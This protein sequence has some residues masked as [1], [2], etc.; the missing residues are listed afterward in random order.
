MTDTCKTCRFWNHISEA[1]GWCQRFP[2][3]FKSDLIG[4]DFPQTLT[5]NWCG[6]HQPKEVKDA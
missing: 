2:P 5:E 4:D 3:Q 1:Y 6:E